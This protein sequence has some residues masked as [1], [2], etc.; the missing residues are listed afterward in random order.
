M[1]RSGSHTRRKPRSRP[2]GVLDV[3]MAGYGF[4][5]TAEG[6]FFVPA[7]KMAG[8]FDGDLV[9]VAPIGT[10]NRRWSGRRGFSAADEASRRPSAR[11]VRVVDRAHDT[12]VGRY[13]LAE[14]FGVV[15]PEDPRIKHDIFT[16]RAE[17][18]NVPDG[19]IVRV[20]ISTFPTRNTAA[21]G[22]VE[23]VI[24]TDC[25]DVLVDLVVARH[26]LETAF[27]E[28]S[29]AEAAAASVDL[30]GAFAEGYRDL[31]DRLIVT[32]DPV[33]A[34]DFDDALSLVPLVDSRARWRLG[35]HIADV[36]HYVSWGSSIDL[37]ARRR[38]TSVYLADRVIPMLPEALSNE[39]CSLKPGA[40]RRAMT[41]DLVLDGDAKVLSVDIY[42]SVIESK[43]RFSYDEVQEVLSGSKRA[44]AIADERTTDLLKGLSVIAKRLAAA[45]AERGGLDFSTSE[46]KVCLGED[47]EPLGIE[48]RRRTDATELVEEAMILANEE[49]ATYLE[50]RHRPG[51]F[52][53]H[54]QPASDSL[55]GLVPVFQEFDWWV[56]IDENLFVAGNPQALQSVLA[57]SEGR[58]ESELVSMLL[59][60]AQKRALYK[61]VCEGHYGLA[62][63]RYAHF[64]SPIRRY[65]D[66]VVHR[67]LKAQ[68][69]GEPSDYR[70]Q[71]DALPWL[72][73]H[74]SE[75]ERV[76][77]AA[78]R[79]SQ[80]C[81]IIEYLKR[82]V[83]RT[84]SAIISGVTAHGV[85]ARLD[86][87]G[88]EGFLPVRELGNDYFAL[89]PV[90]R[91]L[92]GTDTG[93]RYRL[94]QRLA[95]IIHA[96]EPRT[97]LLELRLAKRE[98]HAKNAARGGKKH[99]QR[100]C[101]DA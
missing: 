68:L 43:R 100:G 61:P 64:T 73:E 36:S 94:G 70:E 98:R 53:V 45:R 55:A 56:G 51:I 52:R 59:L 88:A 2:R 37:D 28:A 14:P 4:V 81:K 95:V 22:V 86:D 63:A 15:V 57:A 1:A 77:D 38:A 7:S 33:D 13:E 62:L 11:V 19:A 20:R 74:S 83:G 54:E 8:A 26:K 40:P 78:A 60:R 99:R 87:S 18:P 3:R 32:I 50:N 91:C 96:A 66:L 34:R 17:S 47:G 39:I 35:I 5:K 42:P 76:A 93:K 29:F 21:T 58:P 80:E 75:M 101:A 82:D 24:G 65:P 69:F 30:E 92:E 67:M 79:E 31:R 49:V 84:C 16:M 46:A 12:I 10:P 27:S 89:D 25:D 9:E 90:R 23:E 97:R 48:L 71:R 72:A 6:E 41:V 44:G 85:Y